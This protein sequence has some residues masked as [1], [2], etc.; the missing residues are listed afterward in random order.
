MAV[1]PPIPNASV[2][3]AIAVKA[4]VPPEEAKRVAQIVHT[5]GGES[6]APFVDVDASSQPVPV[7]H[8]CQRAAQGLGFARASGHGVRVGLFQLQRQFRDNIVLPLGSDVQGGD[9]LAHQAL[10]VRHG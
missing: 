7:A 5:A 3:A 9:P 2:T 4:G 6:G 1:L 8:L 10:P